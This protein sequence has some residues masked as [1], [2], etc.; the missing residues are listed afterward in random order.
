VAERGGAVIGYAVTD[1]NPFQVTHGAVVQE[2]SVVDVDGA[3]EVAEALLADAEARA[4]ERGKSFIETAL[5]LED[6]RALAATAARAYEIHSYEGS[7]FMAVVVDAAGFLTETRDELCS[8]LAESPFHDW[9][10]IVGIASSYQCCLLRIA[11]GDLDIETGEEPGAADVLVTVDP[12]GLPLL[13]MGRASVGE[14]YSQD[15][16]TI[17]AADREKALRLLNCLFPRLPAYL[18]RAQWW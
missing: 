17:A 1:F 3:D 18:P 16:I 9:R 15:M 5:S 12:D 6:G 8:R 11:G 13:L 14:L 10:G 2:L 7:V 4:L